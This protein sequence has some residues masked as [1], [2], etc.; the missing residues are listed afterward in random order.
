MSRI[1]ARTSRPIKTTEERANTDAGAILPEM[2]LTA[3]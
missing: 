2:T 3:A 1:S